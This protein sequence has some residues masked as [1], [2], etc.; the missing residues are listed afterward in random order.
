[1][2]TGLFQERRN[3]EISKRIAMLNPSF[4]P[5]QSL[6]CELLTCS[7]VNFWLGL[8]IWKANANAYLWLE[9]LYLSSNIIS[10]NRL[11]DFRFSEK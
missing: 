2:F 11:T 9:C 3:E 5:I 6:V 10:K 1:M 7:H 4:G 8:G